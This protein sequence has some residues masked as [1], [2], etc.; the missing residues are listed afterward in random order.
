MIGWLRQSFHRLRS[1][2]P[3][4][5]LDQELEAEMAVHLELAIDEN[6]KRGMAP[7]EARRQALIRFGGVEQAKQQQREARGL[8]ALDILRQDLRFTFRTLH[9]DRGFTFVAVLV[10]G[11]GIGA[12][13]VVFSVVNTILLRPLP[14]AD[15]QQLAWLAGNNGIGGLSDVTY[16]VDA[17]EEFQ[18]ENRSFEEITA[19]VPYYSL[20]E[21]KLMGN[22]E[23]KPVSF[24]WVAGNFFETFGIQPAL[25]RQFTPEECVR[26]GRK[27]ILLSYPFWQRQFAADP[28]IVGQTIRLN[29]DSVTVV[30]VLP[31]R[32]DFGAVFA[33]GSKI[34]FFRPALMD[35]IR[36]W[37]HMLSLVGRLKPG[38]TVAQA[39]AESSVLFPRLKDS[40]NPDWSTD[41]QTTITGLQDHV[42]GKLRRS[43]I[44]LWCAVVL[45][46]LIVCLNLSNLLLAR[47][48]ARSKEFAMRS[49]LG[50]GRGRLIRQ[51]LTESMV[52]SGA[53][54]VL[55]LGFAL[56]TTTYLAHQGSIALPLLSAIR[57]DGS[58]L[59]WTLLI[60]VSA[61]VLFG[62]APSLRM[63]CGNLQEMLKDTGRG[64]SEG[65]K[66]DHLR[67]AL[68]ISEIALACMLLIG[69]GLLLR[70]FLRVLDVDLGFE[71]S[72]A[73]AI[74]IDCDD[75]GNRARR[76]AI[77]QE[78]LRRVS[79]L[80]G[81]EAAGVADMLP[82]DRNRSWALIA[83]G[84]SP[85]PDKNYDVFVYIVTPGYLNAM[86]MH[87]REGRDF[88]WQ[89]SSV[90]EPVI[91]VNQTAARREWPGEDALGRLAR[92]IGESDTRVV[93]VI[94]DVRDSG[95]EDAPSP[96]V[97]VP[98]TQAEPEGTELVVR[99]TLPP[100]VLAS[101]VM[102][103]LRSINPGQPATEFRPIQQLVDHAVSPRRFFVLL[104]GIFAGLGL[105][106]ASLGIYGVISYSVTQQTQ[107]IGIRMALGATMSRVRVGVIARTLRLA[108]IGIALGVVGSFVVARGIASLLFGTEPTD[109]TT[110][111]GMILLLS[112]V[113]FLAGYIPARR[114]SRIDPMI[115]L[116]SN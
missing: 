88:S 89:D 48:A 35:D 78:T 73:A 14:F 72:H 53:G 29:N 100:D 101:S 9:R 47:A 54:A 115:A 50:A 21:T 94:S 116:R 44:V 77:L 71:P 95:V 62:I 6:V 7:E 17:Y 18:H 45:I 106:L 51:L 81:L 37:G 59:L 25:G 38:V 20:S 55:G 12:N 1:S 102:S 108:L 93:G 34:D 75:G 85:S 46:L 28:A 52:L 113:S 76:G 33:P 82:L 68:V 109:A 57:V 49:A 24:V 4:A 97:Y 103:T 27:A 13:I 3:S 91:I 32:F 79:A 105:L 36:S 60:A 15:S 104:V 58:A 107:E 66:R 31:A 99:T 5:E 22:G 90:S 42:S 86:G 30:G 11:L 10:L 19:F 39:Q 114:A 41:V 63:A 56:V 70:S 80:P 111:A 64:M 23:P 2:F 43:L 16:R 26:G 8:P 87:L 65:R 92:G 67:S 83:K 112:V 61:A 84:K 98:V 74:K 69:A 40:G 96:E 110:F